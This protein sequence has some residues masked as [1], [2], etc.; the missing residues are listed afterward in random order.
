MIVSKYPTKLAFY[1]R[2]GFIFRF[3]IGLSADSTLS[4]L[5]VLDF[6]GQDYKV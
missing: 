6:C 4:F 3:L 1:W 2:W 5:T